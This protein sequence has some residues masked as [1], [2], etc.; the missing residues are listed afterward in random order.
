MPELWPTA[1]KKC[2]G[3][4]G[5]TGKLK[6][7]QLRLSLAAK[8]E[9]AHLLQC[10]I[11]GHQGGPNWPTGSGKG[12]N[13]RLMGTHLPVERLMAID[14][15]AKR[16]KKWEGEWIDRIYDRNS[17]RYVIKF[18]K[19]RTKWQQHFSNYWLNFDKTL[20][21]QKQHQEEQPHEQ[22]HKLPEPTPQQQYHKNNNNNK[23]KTP[24]SQ[25]YICYYWP[26]FD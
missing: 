26:N 8:G 15:N 4:Y 20:K 19:N 2:S 3:F 6:Y 13:P 11:N 24:S 12:F 5:T 10:L 22:Q 21:Q 7:N 25:I 17:G 9:L 23:I 14:C 16:R 1:T 18:S